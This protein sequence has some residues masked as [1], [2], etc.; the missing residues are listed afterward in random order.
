MFFHCYFFSFSF[1]LFLLKPAFGNTLPLFFTYCYYYYYLSQLLLQDHEYEFLDLSDVDDNERTRLSSALLQSQEKHAPASL[2]NDDAA[3]AQ[4][5]QDF[6]DDEYHLNLE[7]KININI[8]SISNCTKVNSTSNWPTNAPHGK[9]KIYLS[10]C[11]FIKK[12]THIL[13]RSKSQ[14]DLLYYF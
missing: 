5:N 13:I 7:N 6:V 1:H 3:D 11:Y 4:N 8:Q 10:N 14:L 9:L 2:I 12:K